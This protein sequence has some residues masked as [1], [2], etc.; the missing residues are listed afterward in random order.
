MFCKIDSRL[1]CRMVIL[2]IC[3]T[4]AILAA[5]FISISLGEVDDDM[6]LKYVA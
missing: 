5:S 1:A 6:P 3:D 2:A 4:A